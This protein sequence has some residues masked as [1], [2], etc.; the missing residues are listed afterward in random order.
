[1]FVVNNFEKIIIIMLMLNNSWE[2]L[3]F[4]G[5]YVPSILNKNS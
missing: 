3:R 1:M 4:F 5:I 2:Y